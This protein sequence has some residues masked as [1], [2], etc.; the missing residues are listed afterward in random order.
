MFT[1]PIVFTVAGSGKS[2]PRIE[3]GPPTS[4]YSTS[5]EAFKL[6]IGQLKTAAGRRRHSAE[7]RQ[8]KS[9]TD[10]ASGQTGNIDAMVRVLIDRPL[11]GFSS[12]EI[13]DLVAAFKTWLDA[14]AVGKLYGGES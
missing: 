14:T 7:F 11:N 4:V 2:M 12:T 6:A 1:E 10:P 3:S 8:T 13:N 5:D 9:Y